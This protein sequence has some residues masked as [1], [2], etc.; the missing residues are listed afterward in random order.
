MLIVLK[1]TWP[2]Y[3]YGTNR[4]GS[5]ARRFDTAKVKSLLDIPIPSPTSLVH[6]L[7]FDGEP[8]HPYAPETVRRVIGA[9]EH[10]AT[11]GG[12]PVGRANWREGKWGEFIVSPQA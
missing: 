4:G 6:A 3:S 9:L 12:G 8:Y 1:Q 10:I 7:G 5:L 2:G 11:S